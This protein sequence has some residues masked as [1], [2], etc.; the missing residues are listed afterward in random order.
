MKNKKLIID[1]DS[2]IIKTEGL[3]ELAEITLKN[4][5]N[6]EEV[7]KKIEE[8]TNM[9]MEGKICF[10][11]SLEKRLSMLS[12]NRNQIEA[13]GEKLKEDVSNSILK[14]IDYL[15]ENRDSIYIISGGFKDFILI[16]VKEL[17][18]R[19]DHVI[20][21]SFIY[22]KEGVVIGFDKSN[23]LSDAG[24]KVKALRGMDIEGERI[25]IG[26][27]WTDYEMREA[28][29]ADKFYAYCEN[30]KRDKVCEVADKVVY[31]FDEIV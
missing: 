16:V 19:E 2:T 17:G 3:E 26:D 4:D 8:I 27:G 5:K 11:E 13:L 20:A 23:P 21:N 1:F 14:N 25:A 29:L 24:G 6:R 30:V 28:G 15:R 18:L 22:N 9:G 7:V 10:R 31:S 12:I